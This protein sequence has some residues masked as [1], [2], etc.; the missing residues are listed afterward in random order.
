MYV[1]I[2]I[3]TP[4]GICDQWLQP[5]QA[6]LASTSM[7]HLAKRPVDSTDL[8]VWPNLIEVDNAILKA[9]I[10][11]LLHHPISDHCIDIH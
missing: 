11:L 9:L 5:A 8:L 4:F 7:A 3:Y 6:Q 10:L 1:C 2:Y